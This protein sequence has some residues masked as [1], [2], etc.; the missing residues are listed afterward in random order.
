M[1]IK[2]NE[3][4][5]EVQEFGPADGPALILIRG[6]GSQ[7][8][9]W[10]ADLCIG[11]AE[12]GFRTIIFDNRDVGLSQRCPTDQTPTDAARILQI[13]ETGA[14]IPAAYTLNDMARDVVGLMDALKIETAHVFGIS[15]GGAIAQILCVDHADRL[16][17][18]SIV[19]TSARLRTTQNNAGSILPT[20]LAKPVD[21]ATYVNNW[22]HEH[23]V[24]G[25]PGY[26]MPEQDI[27]AEADVAWSRGVDPDGNN[28]QVLA[29]LTAPDRRQNLTRIN[30]PCQVI[31]GV[32]DAL[33]P[34]SMGAEIAA[35]IPDC[36][37]HAIDGMGHI[38]TPALA[39]TI[40]DLVDDFI[41]RR[42]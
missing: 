10:P 17:S 5:L 33:I 1:Q 15:M 22:V 21:H 42:G 34:L 28:R 20:L 4:A 26:P 12:R 11:L 32:D 29:L 39:P 3:I 23:A 41:Q 35:L 25:S 37:Y 14:P 8:I 16:K 9:H 18:A 6:L 7:L 2:T 38:I 30:L 36:D 24:H 31:H 27:R 19:M 40:V 13:S